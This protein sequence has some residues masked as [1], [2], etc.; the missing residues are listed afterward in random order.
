ML[1]TPDVVVCCCILYNMVLEGKDI[2]VDALMS[3]PTIIERHHGQPNVR[4]NHR[5]DQRILIEPRITTMTLKAMSYPWKRRAF[6]NKPSH[7]FGAIHWKQAA[8][9]TTLN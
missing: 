5:T 2:D 3:Q 7:H 9:E 1:F 8:S 4:E 6:A